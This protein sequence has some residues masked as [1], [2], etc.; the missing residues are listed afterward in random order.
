MEA[1]PVLLSSSS[2]LSCVAIGWCTGAGVVA[3]KR[4]TGFGVGMGSLLPGSLLFDLNLQ[5]DLQLSVLSQEL[6]VLFLVAVP[7]FS[8]VVWLLLK[9]SKL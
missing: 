2:L 9:L 1:M 8:R 4:A 6:P 3:A 5:L 7:V